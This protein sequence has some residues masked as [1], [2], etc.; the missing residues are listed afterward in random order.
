M[1]TTAG[2]CVVV[3]NAGTEGTHTHFALRSQLLKVFG[4]FTH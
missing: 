1:K 2:G 4:F 3:S